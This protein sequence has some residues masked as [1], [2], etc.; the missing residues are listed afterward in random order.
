MS[1]FY[2]TSLIPF[3][4]FLLRVVAPTSR[5]VANSRILVY[6]N[7]PSH[8]TREVVIISAAILSADPG[9]IHE[10]IAH[11]IQDRVRVSII[12]LSAQVAICEE[13]C[14]R[15]NAGDDSQYNVA[16]H[17]QHFRELLLDKTTPPVT[18]TAEQA[19]ASLLMMGFPSR[20]LASA[21]GVNYCACHNTPFREGYQC[22]RCGTR[23]CRIPA[24]CP[25]CGL[26]LILSTHLA[27]SYHHLIPLRNFLEVP[28]SEAAASVACFACQAPFP[29]PPSREGAAEGAA[30]PPEVK[31]VSESGRYACGLCGSHF[32]IDC[33]VFCHETVH[34]CPG[35]EAGLKKVAKK[36]GENGVKADGRA[37]GPAN[38]E[39]VID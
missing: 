26:T 27:R 37:D 38:G 18:R 1:T 22:T 20:T 36:G 34:N 7:T 23:V 25:S 13:I 11:L 3:S 8:G 21:D 39:M 29:E 10:T 17:E 5:V 6:S 28:W 30:K 14:R 9:D 24:D 4:V 15:T 31:G 16:L 33:D 32:C 35:C 12:G 2:S 19:A